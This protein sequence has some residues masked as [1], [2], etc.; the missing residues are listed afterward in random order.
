MSRQFPAMTFDGLR[1]LLPATW[2]GRGPQFR[3]R[4][5]RFSHGRALFATNGA[6]GNGQRRASAGLT[7][8]R[9]SSGSLR[10]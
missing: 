3:L 5:I 7:R 10:S 2:A 1:E 8:A 4:G 6:F 9:P